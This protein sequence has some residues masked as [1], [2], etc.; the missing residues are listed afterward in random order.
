MGGG[1]WLERGEGETQKDSE[2]QDRK[3]CETIYT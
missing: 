3:N 1:G 2:R